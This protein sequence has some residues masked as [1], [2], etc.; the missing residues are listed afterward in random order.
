MPV[1]PSL[2]SMTPEP[3]QATTTEAQKA[4]KRAQLLKE[5]ERMREMLRDKEKELAELD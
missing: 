1:D 4:I 2:V 5:A 3:P